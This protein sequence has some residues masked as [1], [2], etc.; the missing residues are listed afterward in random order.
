MN[1]QQ[2]ENGPERRGNDD[3]GPGTNHLA[4]EG[5]LSLMS[6]SIQ[7]STDTSAEQRAWDEISRLTSAPGGPGAA[8]RWSIPAKP[9]RDSDLILAAGLQELRDRLDAV[10]RLC[11]EPEY[12][13]TRWEHP[14]PVPAWVERVRDQIKGSVR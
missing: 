8:W 10:A 13:A 5:G 6:D 4:T 2:N 12:H 11:D 3:T 9:D 1:G 14:L 7:N